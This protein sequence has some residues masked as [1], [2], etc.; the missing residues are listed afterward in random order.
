ME[1]DALAFGAHADDVELACAGTIIKLGASGRRTG[2][3]ALTRGEMGTR[4]TAEIRAKEFERSSEIMGLA[5]HTML[6]IPD[7]RIEVNWDNKLKLIKVIRANRPR[8]VFAPYWVD[9]HPD[10]ENASLLVRHT[11]Y[12]AGLKKIDTGQEAWRP[13][14]VIF[15]QG[16]FEFAPSFIVD[17]S[18]HHARKLEAITAYGSQFHRPEGEDAGQPET[19]LSRPGFLER[20]R[21][22]DKRYGAN[23]GV[24]YGEPFFVREALRLDDPVAFF[25]PGCLET[26]P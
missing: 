20:I 5:V 19:Q 12:L 6:D 26:F 24:E 15:Y 8:I 13:Y 2:V 4:G 17:V 3:A 9:R 11:A 14:R 18:E 22:R 16:R 1:L 25:G 7:G 21:A 23:I 10:H